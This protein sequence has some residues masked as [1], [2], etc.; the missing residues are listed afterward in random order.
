M[1]TD[2]VLYQNTDIITLQMNNERF[3]LQINTYF[4]KTT[5]RNS[6]YMWYDKSLTQCAKRLSFFNENIF[7]SININRIKIIV[8]DLQDQFS[9]HVPT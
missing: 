9:A 6:L 8:L 3:F 4:I 5:Q 2:D 7:I 1:H